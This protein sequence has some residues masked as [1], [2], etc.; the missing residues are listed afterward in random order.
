MQE[1]AAGQHEEHSETQ[2]HTRGT[3]VCAHKRNNADI[4]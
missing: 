1:A 2:M 3:R 4:R